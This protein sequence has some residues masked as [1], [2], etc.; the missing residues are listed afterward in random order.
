MKI[1]TPVAPPGLTAMMLV[2]PML[3]PDARYTSATGAAHH[4]SAS[5]ESIELDALVARINE[6]WLAQPPAATS[7][8]RK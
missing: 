6:F 7:G 2:A 4:A 3:A 8:R 5:A 1:N